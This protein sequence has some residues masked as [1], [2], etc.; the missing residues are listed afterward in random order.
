MAAIEFSD[1]AAALSCEQFARQELEMRGRRAKCPWCP[2]PEHYNLAFLPDGKAYC[3]KCHKGGDVVTLAAAV[4]HMSQREAAAELNTRFKLGLGAETVTAADLERRR[5]ARQ[6]DRERREAERAAV[7]AE[8]G[9]AA[10]DLREAEAVAGT[11]TDDTPETWAK[12][13]RLARAQDRW[14]ALQAAG[15]AR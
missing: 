12:V 9:A 2:N 14:N 13:A 11:L 4:W 6:A 5:A 7:N 3:H 8:L 10:E 1:V 15:M